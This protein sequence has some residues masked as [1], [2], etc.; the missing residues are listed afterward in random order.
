MDGRSFL[1]LLNVFW[2]VNHTCQIGHIGT[3]LGAGK[4]SKY[5]FLMWAYAPVHKIPNPHVNN[6]DDMSCNVTSC[7][8]DHLTQWLKCCL[9]AG[10]GPLDPAAM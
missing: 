7:S 2:H 1:K 9:H 8:V 5:K 6:V 4:C 10:L 3:G